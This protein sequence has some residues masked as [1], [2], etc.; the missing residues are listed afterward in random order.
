M[1]V[2]FKIEGLDQLH[3]ASANMVQAV[4]KEV[5]KA[6]FVSA[7]QVEKEAKLSIASGQKSG[8]VYQRGSVTHRASAPGE[9]PAS[10]TGRLINSIA[11]YL[12]SSKGL[13][14]FVVAGRGI[15]KYAAMLEFGTSKMAARP[16]L[17]PALEKS[18]AFIQE[19]LNKAV[20]DAAIKSVKK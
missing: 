7:Q 4:N 5:T 10:D 11:S 19:R 13:E 1:D 2:S 20:R 6:L 8:R 15:V 3:K 14:S 12:N 17:F 9:A 16:F 18:K